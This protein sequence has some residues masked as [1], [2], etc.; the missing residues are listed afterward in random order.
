MFHVKYLS[1]S[2]YG[3]G[4]DF[5]S[6]FWLPWQPQFSMELNSMNNFERAW[7][8]KHP[9]QVLSNLAKWFRRRSHFIEKVYGRTD[10]RT[11][12]ITV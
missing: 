2:L 8:Q 11:T 7:C 9:H 12:D 5:L 10:G 1:S 6:F 3:L 4:E